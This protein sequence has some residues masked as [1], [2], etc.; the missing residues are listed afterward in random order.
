MDAALAQVRWDRE[1]ANP[2]RVASEWGSAEI[3]VDG[4]TV[5]IEVPHPKKRRLLQA[6]C[7]G[8]PEIPPVVQFPQPGHAAGRR[9][10]LLALRRQRG[11]QDRRGPPVDMPARHARI[12]GPPRR[13][14][15]RSVPR[16][17]K[18]RFFERAKAE[19]VA[20]TRAAARFA[21]QD[22]YS[23]RPCR[24][25]PAPAGTAGNRWR[26]GPEYARAP[27]TAYGASCSPTSSKGSGAARRSPRCR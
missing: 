19:P 10:R 26:T 3:S 7:E 16:F 12:R 5:R 1:I 20:W 4:T 21:C 14:C 22:R 2:R 17:D 6:R 18:Q 24:A 27:A 11:V 8:Y 15:V 25:S 9:R 23:K 13:L